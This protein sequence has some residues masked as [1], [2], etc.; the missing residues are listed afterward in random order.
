MQQ[1]I[2]AALLTILAL[3][4]LGAAM[5]HDHPARA[6]LILALALF[7]VFMWGFEWGQE[8]AV[9]SMQEKQRHP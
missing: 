2:G 5:M 7:G 1:I 6:I 4:S 3:L 9:R 8:R